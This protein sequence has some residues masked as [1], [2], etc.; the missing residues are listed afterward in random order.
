MVIKSLAYVRL[1]L[2]KYYVIFREGGGQKITE[3]YRGGPEGLQ[4]GL[5]NIWMF[6]NSTEEFST[7]EILILARLSL[8]LTCTLTYLGRGGTA[9]HFLNMS[10]INRI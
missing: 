8:H 1:L 3:D 5:R 7:F 4:K 9:I 6:P 2:C 10:K